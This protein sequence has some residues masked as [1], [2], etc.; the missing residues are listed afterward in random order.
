MQQKREYIYFEFP[1]KGGQVAIRMG[2]WKG[3][4]TNVRQNVKAPWQLYNLASDIA[5]KKDVAADHREIIKQ[6]IAIA[7]K[8]HRCAHIKEWEFVDPRFA[9]LQG[10]AKTARE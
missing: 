7:Q 4:R 9:P 6:L 1:E 3:V 2:Y 8:E 5:E 10:V